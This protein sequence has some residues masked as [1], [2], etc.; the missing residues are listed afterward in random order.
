MALGFFSLTVLPKAHV[1]HVRQSLFDPARA[2][3]AASSR[4]L[5]AWPWPSCV[6]W[7][8]G[9]PALWMELEVMN[10]GIESEA[11]C[12]GYGVVDLQMRLGMCC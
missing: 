2:T 9:V 1:S 7:A 12:L 3:R 10:V 8:R 4:K 11:F 5:A 6:R